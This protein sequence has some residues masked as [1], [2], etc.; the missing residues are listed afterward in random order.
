MRNVQ[1]KAPE[2]ASMTGAN[3]VR[4]SDEVRCSSCVAER[5]VR[6]TLV[7]MERATLRRRLR[8]TVQRVLSRRHTALKRRK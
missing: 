5:P 3:C 7:Q 2:A 8:T 1:V 4:A 6:G